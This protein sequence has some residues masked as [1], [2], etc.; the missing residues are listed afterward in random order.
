[1]VLIPKDSEFWKKKRKN[2]LYDVD[3][4]HSSS[5]E[6]S[7]KRIGED[8]QPEGETKEPTFIVSNPEDASS[9]NKEKE[10]ITHECNSADTSHLSKQRANSKLHISLLD[11]YMKLAEND[12][13]DSSR[14]A[15]LFMAPR[16]TT[17]I[18]NQIG[19]GLSE[20][21]RFRKISSDLEGKKCQTTINDNTEGVSTRPHQK[22]MQ[23]VNLI[24]EPRPKK[25]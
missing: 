16:H 11:D 4:S 7:F 5:E 3:D 22:S 14:G 17:S 20:N 10:P 24:K 15:S 1:M 13:S 25:G 12:K 19:G 6:D 18:E 21:E 8:H 9:E 2:E 23:N